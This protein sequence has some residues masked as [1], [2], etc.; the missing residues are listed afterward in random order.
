[1]VRERD[2]LALDKEGMDPA[3]QPGTL[4]SKDAN[5]YSNQS[6][7]RLIQDRTKTTAQ[8]IYDIVRDAEFE[9]KRAELVDEAIM[10]GSWEFN[11]AGTNR[12][13][14]LEELED[15]SAAAR[16]DI[17]DPERAKE[18]DRQALEDARLPGKERP[19]AY[20]VW[21]G[22]Y[23]VLRYNYH[24]LRQEIAR[25]RESG[26]AFRDY[27]DVK[28]RLAAGA[29]IED[30]I[31]DLPVHWRKVLVMTNVSVAKEGIQRTHVERLVANVAESGGQVS[32]GGFFGK[33]RGGRGRRRNQGGEDSW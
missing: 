26:R 10:L 6:Y 25:D 14:R 28:Q 13:G 17:E 21:E 4:V 18:I 32:S 31:D 8:M 2:G 19:E 16:K 30:V 12:L 11:A 20:D 15:D 24:S 33:G 3:L 7:Q 9:P 5:A 27:T 29:T 1:M 23:Y 22:L